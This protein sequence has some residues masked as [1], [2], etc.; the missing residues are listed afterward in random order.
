MY[1]DAVK[2]FMRFVGVPGFVTVIMPFMKVWPKLTG[3]ANTLP[4]DLA[5][6][7]PHQRGHPLRAGR[8]SD[9]TAPV[10]VAD[11]GKSPAWMRNGQRA[12]AANL[13]AAYQTLEGQTHMVKADAQAP[14]IIAF[15][16]RAAPGTRA[17]AA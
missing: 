2:L 15:F 3:I 12:L 1:G 9:V 16:T 14:M 13:D 17:E 6:V 11:G 8:W 7:G 5:I 10:L 4:Y